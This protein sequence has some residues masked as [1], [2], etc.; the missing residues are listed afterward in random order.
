MFALKTSALASALI[1]AGAMGSVAAQTTKPAPAKPAAPA[2]APATAGVGVKTLD[3]SAASATGKVMN[4]N[5]LR[6]CLK[7]QDSLD[8]RRKQLDGQRAQLDAER[9]KIQQEAAA[10]KSESD[11]LASKA[12]QITAF[13]AKS[14]A[15]SEKVAAFNQRASELA[16]NDRTGPS[17]DRAR[18]QL[19]A[20]QKAL[21]QEEAALK[22]EGDSLTSGVQAAG[23]TLKARAEAQQQAATDWNTRNAKLNDQANAYE[24]ERVNWR[25][26]CGNRRY[27][28]DDEKAL[29]AEPK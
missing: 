12:D 23:D 26:D 6:A 5:E 19:D 1:L 29:R 9:D 25:A 13:N 10:L 21:A 14:K 8:T 2:A 28:E 22:A 7:Q 15:F 24:D 18:R 17:V 11:A 3:G 27:R 20:D 4:I 16:A